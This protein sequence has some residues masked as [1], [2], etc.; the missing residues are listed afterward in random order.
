LLNAE[1]AHKVLGS[2]LEFR[3]C[4]A[5]GALITLRKSSGEDVFPAFQFVNGHP[6]P[7]LAAAHH[8]LSEYVSSWTA[9]AWCV[10]DHPE[11]AM[12][13]PV[14]WAASERDPA[15]LRRIARRDAARLAD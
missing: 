9:A 6:L 1:Q 14:A 4:R 2:A 3:R 7:E 15:R 13:S 8:I 11:L 10:G 5:S 12:E